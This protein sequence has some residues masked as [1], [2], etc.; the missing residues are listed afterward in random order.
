MIRFEPW[1]EQV[2][3]LR[4]FVLSSTKVRG[5]IA[6]A[7]MLPEGS[8]SWAVIKLSHS[9]VSSPEVKTVGEQV[10]GM[11]ND[12][13]CVIVVTQ[14]VIKRGD[15]EIVFHPYTEEMISTIV[16]QLDI[17][18][19]QLTFK[20]PGPIRDSYEATLNELKAQLGRAE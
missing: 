18:Y 13:A 2:E 4:P 14:P 12:L 20:S 15:F 6:Y 19:G 16:E 7:V 3:E 9:I 1:G 17:A 8:I 5:Q 11:G 10:E